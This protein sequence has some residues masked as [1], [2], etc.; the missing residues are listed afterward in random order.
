MKAH[1]KARRQMEA[2]G[3]DPNRD[4]TEGTPTEDRWFGGGSH[5]WLDRLRRRLRRSS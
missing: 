2:L 3:Q 4:D 1:G 5:G